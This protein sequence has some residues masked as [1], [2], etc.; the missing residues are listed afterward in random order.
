MLTDCKTKFLGIASP[1][2]ADLRQ[3]KESWPPHYGRRRLR[4]SIAINSPESISVVAAHLPPSPAPPGGLWLAGT[5]QDVAHHLYGFPQTDFSQRCR[6]PPAPKFPQTFPLT[7]TILKRNN[8]RGQY[9][10]GRAPPPNNSNYQ[11][12]RC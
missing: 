9:W 11:Y 12:G 5:R 6:E 1:V 7:T 8:H 2:I 3:P 4:R 10:A